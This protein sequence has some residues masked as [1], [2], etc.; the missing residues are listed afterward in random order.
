MITTRTRVLLCACSV[1]VVLLVAGCAGYTLGTSLP[2]NIRTVHVPL[3]VNRSGEPDIEGEVTTA[4]IQEFQREG[5][6]SVVGKEEADSVLVVRLVDYSLK[7]LRY[8]E[9][10]VMETR[11]Y[12]LTLT[13]RMILKGRETDGVIVRGHVSGETTFEA[14]GDLGVAKRSALPDV[15]ADLARHIVERVVEAW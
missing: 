9:D 4:V 12:R 5:T 8:S 6:L 14:P 2:A 11:E 13:A 3:F 7:P 10:N 15:S 1:T